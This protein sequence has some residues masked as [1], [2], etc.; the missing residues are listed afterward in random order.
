MPGDEVHVNQGY[1]AT[2][3]APPKS[4]SLYGGGQSAVSQQFHAVVTPP[5]NDAVANQNAQRQSYDSG[6]DAAA[7]DHGRRSDSD[8]SSATPTRELLH[9]NGVVN[10]SYSPGYAPPMPADS[11]INQSYS[12]G[13]VPPMPTDSAVNQTYTSDFAPPMR[14]GSGVHHSYSPGYAPPMRTDSGHVAVINPTYHRS[15]ERVS[16]QNVYDDSQA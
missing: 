14:T 11:A 9:G 8:R 13:F 15:H 1:H 16:T 7:S 10:H 5:Y 4:A 2:P 12:P 6:R 3:T